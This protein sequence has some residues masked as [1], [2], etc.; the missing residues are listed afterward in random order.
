MTHGARSAPF[1]RLHQPL[2]LLRR[3]AVCGIPFV[4]E[5][6]GVQIALLLFV[7][8]LFATYMFGVRP[9]IVPSRQ[10]TEMANEALLLLTS[11]VLVCLSPFT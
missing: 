9:H 5:S 11:Y 7:Q 6:A 1:A 8:Q 2:M 4:A 3:F 10:W